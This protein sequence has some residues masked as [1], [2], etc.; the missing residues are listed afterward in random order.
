M[1]YK[2]IKKENHQIV[3]NYPI[4]LPPS[5]VLHGPPRGGS[6]KVDADDCD[7]AKDEAPT[8]VVG[9]MDMGTLTLDGGGIS[10]WSSLSKTTLSNC[11]KSDTPSS[12]LS[13]SGLLSQNLKF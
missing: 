13:S 10:I 11:S 3:K 4:L 7:G 12:K 6:A 2:V 9:I 1:T 5:R 8:I